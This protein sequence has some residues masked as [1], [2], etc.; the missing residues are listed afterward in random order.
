[1]FNDLIDLLPAAG[2]IA[3]SPWLLSDARLTPSSSAS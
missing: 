1:M 3:Y 2:F